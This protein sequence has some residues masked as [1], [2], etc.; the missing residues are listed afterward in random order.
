MKT[1]DLEVRRR[2]RAKNR[3]EKAI[4]FSAMNRGLVSIL[5]SS[6][7]CLACLLGHNSAVVSFEKIVREGKGDGVKGE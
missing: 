3:R 5:M 7:V 6:F 2:K 4:V 1:F